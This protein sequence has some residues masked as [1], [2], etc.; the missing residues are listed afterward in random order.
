MSNPSSSE[1][2]ER[3]FTWVALALLTT[4]ALSFFAVR[5]AKTSFAERESAAGAVSIWS[6]DRDQVVRDAKQRVH[7]MGRGTHFSAD[8]TMVSLVSGVHVSGIGFASKEELWFDVLPEWVEGVEPGKAIDLEIRSPLE[9]GTRETVLVSLRITDEEEPIDLELSSFAGKDHVTVDQGFVIF[10]YRPKGYAPFTFT[11]ER[12]T[13]G[14]EIRQV[15][16]SSLEQLGVALE[17]GANGFEVR[18]EDALGR[19]VLDFVEVEWWP[20]APSASTLAAVALSGGGYS[21]PPISWGAT[22]ADQ[23]PAGDCAMGN[24]PSGCV[25]CGEPEGGRSVN[26][27]IQAPP[28]G[29]VS[30]EAQASAGV[31]VEVHTGDFVIDEAVDLVV[32]GRGLDFVWTRSYA[33]GINLD[34]WLGTNWDF[35]YGAYFKADTGAG[36]GDFSRGDT[37]RDTYSGYSSMTGVFSSHPDGYFDI[38]TGV[39]TLV[40]EVQ[41]TKRN[42]FVQK[43]DLTTG[44]L[45]SRADRYGN[46]IS[47]TYDYTGR[48]TSIQDT[49]GRSH[50]V[51]Y[52]TTGAANGRITKVQDSTGRAVEYEYTTVNSKSMLTKVKYPA[53]DWIDDTSTTWVDKTS[54]SRT[55][56]YTYTTATIPKLEKVID[57]RN[58]E[59]VLNAYDGSSGRITTQQQY[60]DATNT[61]QFSWVLVSLCVTPGHDTSLMLPIGDRVGFR[62]CP[63]RSPL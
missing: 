28:N 17:E 13:N 58:K 37:R 45:K 22:P 42:G 35:G 63:G 46:T 50:N 39:V 10:G 59:R 23:P 8:T 11:L 1:H 3:A 48:I 29:Y 4:V 30:T 47:V 41:Q 60:G 57:G 25:S 20:R 9:D 49:L 56:Q 44:R 26:D 62:L 61:H 5:L 43:F 34:G 21:G 7:V 19:E 2:V 51:Y 53:T 54:T 6:I 33:S 15:T 18:L 31:G 32:P 55:I 27:E 38:Q 36:T 14:E 16:E 52:G 24:D 12:L 40:S